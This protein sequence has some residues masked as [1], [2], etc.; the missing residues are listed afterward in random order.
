[1]AAVK[2]STR[3]KLL[4]IKT[5]KRYVLIFLSFSRAS[6]VRKF[7]Y[8]CI[9]EIWVLTIIHPYIHSFMFA[10]VKCPRHILSVFNL[11]LD[12]HGQ[13][14]AVKK[15]SADYCHMSVSLPQVYNSLT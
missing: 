6:W 10:V 11:I 2:T 3:M 8:L 13:L 1:M 9:Q 5:T 7:G 4:P 15:V 12:I 14:T